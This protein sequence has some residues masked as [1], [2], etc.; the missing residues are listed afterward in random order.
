MIVNKLS[1]NKVNVQEVIVTKVNVHKAHI[2]KVIDKLVLTIDLLSV[3]SMEDD[4]LPSEDGMG[5]RGSL[6]AAQHHGG[7]LHL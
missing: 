7:V 5:G 3:N 6:P 4:E 2:D 1:V